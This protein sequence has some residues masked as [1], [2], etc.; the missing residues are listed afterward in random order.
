MN[1]NKKVISA[2]AAIGL[3][4]VFIMAYA[5]TPLALA[6]APSPDN[7]IEVIRAQTHYKP[8]SG[9]TIN[10]PTAF[11]LSASLSPDITLVREAASQV[12]TQGALLLQ[13]AGDS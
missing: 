4:S 9:L 8:A 12:G 7:Q 13:A 11:A 6:K 2:V 1:S 5:I 3:A 10:P